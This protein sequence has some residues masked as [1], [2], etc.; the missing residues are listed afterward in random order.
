MYGSNGKFSRRMNLFGK[1]RRYAGGIPGCDQFDY[2]TCAQETLAN[3][4]R[5]WQSLCDAGRT[6]GIARRA[7]HENPPVEMGESMRDG[8]IMVDAARL[9]RIASGSTCSIH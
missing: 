9:E 8:A 1:G 7:I 3:C 5:G 4:K 2:A 6:P